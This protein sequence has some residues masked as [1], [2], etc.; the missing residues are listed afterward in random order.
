[1]SNDEIYILKPEI[2]IIQPPKMHRLHQI[3]NTSVKCVTVACIF[4]ACGHKLL[5][6]KLMLSNH[7]NQANP[8]YAF[9]AHDDP[10]IQ[11]R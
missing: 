11:V 6:N 1:M 3:F 9:Q 2:K 8:V 7:S 4:Q 10:F 5:D